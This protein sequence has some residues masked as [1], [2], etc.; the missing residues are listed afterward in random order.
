MVT[1][2]L[3]KQRKTKRH[4]FKLACMSAAQNVFRLKYKKR[5]CSRNEKESRTREWKI[6]SERGRDRKTEG[7]R[8]PVFRDDVTIVK[9]KA[10]H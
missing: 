2:P 8:P 3:E 9:H 1:R 10:S 6:E 4:L 5:C 7:K